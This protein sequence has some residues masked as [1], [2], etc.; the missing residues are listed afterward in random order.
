MANPGAKFGEVWDDDAP[1][2]VLRPEYDYQPAYIPGDETLAKGDGFQPIGNAVM[3]VISHVADYLTLAP[4]CESPI[5]VMFGVAMTQLMRTKETHLRLVPQW[6]WRRYRI[7]WALLREHDGQP[8][9]FVECDGA[10][11]HSTEAQK[12]RDREK[13]AAAKSAGI[14]VFRFTGS[15]LFRS[16]EMC[17][18]IVLQ[19]AERNA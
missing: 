8:V 6:Q 1:L 12:R 3:E 7:D 16:A 19:A 15:D 13:D 18:A 14:D 5:E 17:A 9:G 10:E 2:D 11:F 4:Q